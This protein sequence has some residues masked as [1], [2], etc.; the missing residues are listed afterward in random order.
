LSDL[1]AG[2]GDIAVGNL[3]ITLARKEL[4]DFSDP[5]L[6]GVREYVVTAE[7]EQ[8][9]TQLADLAGRE[10]HVRKSSSYF[11]SLVAANG[12]L[13]AAKLDP[14]KIVEAD[15]RLEDE[16]LI[17]MVQAGLLPAIVVDSHKAA[18]WKQVFP[19]ITVHE[20]LALRE[21]GE[22]GWAF[23]KNSPLLAEAINGFA[24]Q[25]GEGTS[26]G[27]TLLRRY[28]KNTKWLKA[29]N[30]PESRKRMAELRELF[31]KYGDQ[32]EIDWLLVAAQSYQESNFDQGRRNPS[33]A[34]GL[35]QIKPT[36]AADPNVG[37][38]DITTNADNNVHA[39]VKYLRFIADQY[40]DGQGLDDTNRIFLALAAYNAGPNRVAR[41]R[42]KAKNP[43]IWFGEV[44][45]AVAKRTGIEPVK[46]VSN[47]LKYY[48]FFKRVIDNQD[49]EAAK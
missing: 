23:R 7:T 35:M 47:I 3:T 11:E 40:F 37:I 6:T 17:D 36:T 28:F 14:I 41:E 25:A 33:G 32:Y 18:F 10:V 5:V 15:E 39:G 1:V 21:D 27:N 38:K 4:V 20:G 44:E 42:G 31:E 30:G 22:I 16:D 8:A 2:R 49:A 13:E 45:W 24:K 48:I 12:T 43:N 19:H 26:V 34:V 9:I 29:A 46:Y